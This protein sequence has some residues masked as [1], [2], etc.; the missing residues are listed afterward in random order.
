[1]PVGPAPAPKFQQ[2]GAVVARV[3]HNHE[4]TGSNPVPATKFRRRASE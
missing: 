1:M 3:A 4:V 2:D